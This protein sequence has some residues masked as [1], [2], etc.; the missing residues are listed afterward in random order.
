[1]LRKSL[2][3]ALIVAA[4]AIAPSAGRAANQA[5]IA[6]ATKAA[7]SWLTLIDEGKYGESWQQAASIFRNAITKDA[8]ARQAA[9]VRTPLGAV[10]SRKLKIARYETRLPG[11]PDGEYVVIQY[12]TS[13]ANKKSAVE[14]VT[15][16]LG[17]DGR[18]HVSGYYIR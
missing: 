1:M 8:W 12:A 7:D 2:V 5:A 9:A 4:T 13:F 10:E 11:A 17:K 15:P 16:M 6:K 3:L 18:W 14:T